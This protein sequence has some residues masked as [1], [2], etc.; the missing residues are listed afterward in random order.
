MS[1]CDKLSRGKFLTNPIQREPN[2]AESFFP[3]NFDNIGTFG[4]IG[5]PY[6]LRAYIAGIFPPKIS[7]L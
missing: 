4:D 6:V 2:I 5:P 1:K 7:A 3:K